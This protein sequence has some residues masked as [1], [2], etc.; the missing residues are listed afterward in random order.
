MEWIRALKRL[1]VVGCCRSGRT[2]APGL[3]CEASSSAHTCARK[4]PCGGALVVSQS[5]LLAWPAPVCL[6]WVL[7]ACMWG[8][9]MVAPAPSGCGQSW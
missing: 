8:A 6:G 1:I 2:R 9:E 3:R 7:T 5:P 4:A